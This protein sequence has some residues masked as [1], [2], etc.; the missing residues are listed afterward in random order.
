MK[1]CH[2]KMEIKLETVFLMKVLIKTFEHA[3]CSAHAKCFVIPVRTGVVLGH[4]FAFKFIR[5]LAKDLIAIWV[6]LN[7][8]LSSSYNKKKKIQ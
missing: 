3:P 1:V 2:K 4:R 6:K 7:I 5:F 8:G